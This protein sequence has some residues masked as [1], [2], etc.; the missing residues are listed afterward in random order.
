LKLITKE[1]DY[2]IR[3]LGCISLNSSDVLTVSGLSKELDMPK[4][5]LRKILQQLNKKG[6]L[7]SYKGKGG[8][9]VLNVDPAGISVLEIMEI[10]QGR[11]RLS[12]HVFQGRICPIIKAC[13]F[14][15]RLDKIEASVKKQLESITIKQLTSKNRKGIRANG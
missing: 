2:A 8:G 6:I 1:T 13:H 7:K 11:F 9:F 10:F 15:Q 14:K 3:A 12:E 5:F 4:C